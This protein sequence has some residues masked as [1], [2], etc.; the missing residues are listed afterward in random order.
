MENTKIIDISHPSVKDSVIILLSENKLLTAKQIHNMAETKFGKHISYQAIHKLLTEMQE[1][2]ILLK[3]EKN[4]SLNSDWVKNTKKFL[5]N[6]EKESEITQ[7]Q[8]KTT[9]FVNSSYHGWGRY[10]LEF[11]ANEVDKGIVTDPYSVQTHIWWILVLQKDEFVWFKKLGEVSFKVLCKKNTVFD[12]CMASF[13]SQVGHKIKLGADY[14]SNYELLLY[15]NKVIQIYFPQELKKII[16]TECQN[17]KDPNELFSP[18]YKEIM[19][20]PD[21]KIKTI[22]IEDAQ[23]ANTLREELKTCFEATPK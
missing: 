20:N 2:G 4:Y 13:Y 14:E 11:L 8:I 9:T 15:G 12:K 3:A 17:L 19:Y 23:F 5:E 10:M 22:I 21:I 1:K 18:K 16:E 7:N 6:A